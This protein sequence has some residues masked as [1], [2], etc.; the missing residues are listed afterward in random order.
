M[1]TCSIQFAEMNVTLGSYLLTSV[2]SLAGLRMSRL[3]YVFIEW[4]LNTD[5]LRVKYYNG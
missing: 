4:D 2:I 5:I 3:I 1:H